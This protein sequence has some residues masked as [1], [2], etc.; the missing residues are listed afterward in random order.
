MHRVIVGREFYEPFGLQ[1][2]GLAWRRWHLEVAGSVRDK[3]F[4][5]LAN[6]PAT[7]LPSRPRRLSRPWR[8]R[9]PSCYARSSRDRLRAR[10]AAAPR[11][12]LRARNSLG[13][14]GCLPACH[15]A[16]PS[17]RRFPLR[18][19]PPTHPGTILSSVFPI[20]Y[21]AISEVEQRFPGVC[22]ARWR[23]SLPVGRSRLDR[24]CPSSDA[25][26][27]RL[28]HPPCANLRSPIPPLQTLL[29]S[30]LGCRDS[31]QATRASGASTACRTMGALLRR[32]CKMAAA[33]ELPRTPPPTLT[34]L[35]PPPICT[36]SYKGEH[37][38][39]EQLSRQFALPEGSDGS[40][41]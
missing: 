23:S 17:Q 39:G 21:F 31:C 6:H 28:L 26:L 16:L 33:P 8:R 18:A 34:H 5:G 41:E 25:E 10:V 19:R 30:M 27:P 14:P 11:R 15:F 4:L 35:T 38:S 20:N 13:T 2:R 3:A 40:E 32:C 37:E 1:A 24:R 12:F 29:M 22:R 36:C 7:L 9:L